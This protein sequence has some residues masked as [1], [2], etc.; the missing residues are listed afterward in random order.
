MPLNLGNL[1]LRMSAGVA[2]FQRQMRSAE[3]AVNKFGR[4]VTRSGKRARVA[5]AGVSKFGVAMKRLAAQIS[6][7]IG[8]RQLIQFFKQAALAF[9][10]AQEK[11]TQLATAMANQ[12]TF[13]IAAAREALQFSS[14]L[15][16]QTRFGDEAITTLQTMLI[17]LGDLEGQGL[18]RATMAALDFAQAQGKDLKQ[19]AELFGKAA[20]GN[21]TALTRY[22]GKFEATGDAGK[23]FEAVLARIEERMGGSAAAAFDTAAGKIDTI[24]NKWAD[25]SETVG[26]TGFTAEI[27]EQTRFIVTEWEKI[28]RL[29]SGLGDLA[30]GA[31]SAQ[32]AR[33]DDL[34]QQLKSIERTRKGSLAKRAAFF[35]LGRQE[36]KFPGKRAD[37]Q[38]LA[39]AKEEAAIRQTILEIEKQIE[40]K[41]NKQAASR[42]KNQDAAKKTQKASFSN[43]RSAEETG[44]AVEV[45][46]RRGEKIRSEYEKMV[47]LQQQ[48]VRDTMR[49]DAIWQSM[50]ERMRR[51][52]KGA[53]EVGL[54]AVVGGS[55]VIGNVLQGAQQGA[56]VGGPEGAVAGA[57]AGLL[58]SSEA[59]QTL[60]D[61]VGKDL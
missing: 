36:V 18:R 46:F 43:L 60:M 21:I 51:F 52:A 58:T 14:A 20:S 11:S 59:F 17:T 38:S 40:A 9:A 29:A 2:K 41:V 54:G 49:A 1:N 57:I 47:E 30:P 53:G 10:D 48:L 31:G 35:V 24:K 44:N 8:A 5:S 55:A 26:R 3:N 42:K 25:L 12:G 27:L 32:Q 15:Q 56:A 37:E 33:L 39:F 4:R 45:W 13:T 16:N 22:I 7:F 19:T 61:V 50:G 6:V 23:D 34:N 28:I